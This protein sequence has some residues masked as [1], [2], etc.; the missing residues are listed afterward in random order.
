MK[1]AKWLNNPLERLALATLV[2]FNVLPPKKLKSLLK[3][4]P[5]VQI[6]DSFLTEGEEKSQWLKAE[7]DKYQA[8]VIILGDDNYPL[9][10]EEIPSAPVVLFVLG[11]LNSLFDLF[12][13]G[14]VGT[15]KPT[16]Y[17]T[18]MAAS[19]TR[20]LVEKGWTTVSGL[21]FGVDSIVHRQTLEAGG[22]TIAVIP[23]GLDAIYPSSHRHLAEEIV[24]NSGA[25]ITEIGFGQK[26]VNRGSFPRR[27]RIVAGISKFLVVVEG[28]NKSG[29]LITAAQAIASGREVYAFPGRVDNPYSWAPNFLIQQGARPI[30]SLEDFGKE[31]KAR[32]EGKKETKEKSRLTEEERLVISCLEKK[33]RPLSLEEISREIQKP[34]EGVFT[35]LNQMEFKGL[36]ELNPTGRYLRS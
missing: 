3:Q 18:K 9:Y 15:R 16:E 36:V 2:N 32:Q 24:N 27:N 17:G 13:A 35:L 31:L 20:L 6:R 4:S 21:A 22:R 14:V 5:P 33:G 19:I 30:I 28:T 29:T 25:V 1:K 23:S 10:L 34:V 7:L 26:G 12:S 8:R 11:E